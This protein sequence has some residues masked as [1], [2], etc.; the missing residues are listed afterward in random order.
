MNAAEWTER[1]RLVTES[2]TLTGG[3]GLLR[4]QHAQT[5]APGQFRLGFATEWFSAGFLCTSQFPCPGPGGTSIT[6]DAL[7]HTGGTLSLSASLFR[8]GSGTFDAY[9]SVMAL[10]NSDSANNPPL[11]QVVGDMNLGAKYVAPVSSI[12][13]LGVFS[14]VWLINASGSAKFDGGGTSAK[15]GGLFTTDVRALDAHVPLRISLNTVYSLDNTGDVLSD[16]EGSRGRP[17]PRIARFGLGVNRVDHFDALIGAEVFLADERVRPFLE[18]KFSV[19]FNRQKYDCRLNNPSKDRCLA[20]DSFLPAI[21]TVGGRFFPWKRGFSLL[22]A[23]DV[24]LSGTSEFVEELQPTPPWTLFLGAGWATDTLDRPPVV[25]VVEKA[26]PLRGHV[27]GFV[28]E[29]SKNDP[30]QGAVVTYR[31]RADLAPL[32]TGKDGKFADDL[33]MGQ[34]GYEVKAD[35]FK[36]GSCD[37]VV[38]KEGGNVSIDCPLEASPRIGTVSGRLLDATSGEPI[39]GVPI[40]LEDTQH[41]ELRIS[42][43]ASGGF[44]FEGASAGSARLVVTADGY[45]ALVEPADVKTRREVTVLLAL[46]PRPKTA[47]V[48]V[49][50]NEITIRQQIQFAVDSATILPESFGLMTEIADTILRHTEIR[51]IEVQGHTDNTGTPDHNKILS[52]QRADAVRIWLAEHGVGS[53]R[54][55]ARGYGQDKPL[56][57]N[58]TAGN[59]AQNRRVQFLILEREGQAPAGGQ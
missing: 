36:A 52:E 24:G 57:P 9:G 21:L 23:L 37:A 26:P 53:E 22:A 25:K 55:M 32:A 13:H 30:I 45:L 29:T 2:N 18:S 54:L 6:S 27:V 43:D 33:P 42:S 4:T 20:N 48:R 38:G 3:T 39:A 59:R 40:V 51:R 12:F 34:Y 8:I 10:A 56:A 41:K 7:D 47:A 19:P 5:G 44:R 17:V 16:T 31:D 35:G 50:A 11:L 15:F 28:H 58:V 1:D 46:R 49:T 14:E